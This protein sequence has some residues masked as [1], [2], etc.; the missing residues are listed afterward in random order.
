MNADI[1]VCETCQ[2]A[3]SEE[4]MAAPDEVELLC[5]E[6]GGEIA[7]HL[8]EEIELQGQQRCGCGCHQPAKDTL[9]HAT[10]N[11]GGRP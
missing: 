9:R 5:L 2:L 1:E 6:L 11:I 10:S 4:G 7:D 8:C 3:A